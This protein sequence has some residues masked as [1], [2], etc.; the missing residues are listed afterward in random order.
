MDAQ[1]KFNWTMIGIV[2]T[3]VTGLI[4]AAFAFGE[5][6]N[7]IDGIEKNINKQNALVSTHFADLETKIVDFKRVVAEV[8]PETE[9]S[10]EESAANPEEIEKE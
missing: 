2:A 3:V 7:Q 1:S 10:S 5:H 9:V 6:F 4:V 8:H